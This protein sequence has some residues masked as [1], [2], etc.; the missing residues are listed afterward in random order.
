[1]ST[2]SDIAGQRAGDTGHAWG[3]ALMR[4]WVAYTAWRV[5]RLAIERLQAMS[6]RQLNDIGLVCSQ[7][8]FAARA[9][10]E[11]GPAALV[12]RPQRTR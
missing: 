12:S 9:A 1:M 4:W 7:L 6:D 10:S 8:P 11:Q 5:E 2:L 3:S